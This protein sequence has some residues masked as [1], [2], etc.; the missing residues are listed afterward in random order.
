MTRLRERLAQ[1]GGRQSRSSVAVTVALLVPTCLVFAE[2]QPAQRNR[3]STVEVQRYK[4]YD[5]CFYASVD[6]TVE[7]ATDIRVNLKIQHKQ[8]SGQ[9][10][11]KSAALKVLVFADVDVYV[12]PDT[13]LG[14]KRLVDTT[15]RFSDGLAA[16]ALTIKKL[17][18]EPP[19]HYQLWLSCAD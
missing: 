12:P 8:S 2:A 17:N 16:Y 18:S 14:G 9:C 3:T 7:S 13:P 11:C 5:A 1:I 15:P 10:G 19:Q 4:F 6:T